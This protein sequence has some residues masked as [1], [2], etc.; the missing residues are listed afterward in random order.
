[1]EPCIDLYIPALYYIIYKIKISTSLK[2]GVIFTDTI[3]YSPN[4]HIL[5]LINSTYKAKVMTRLR[6]HSSLDMHN[7]DNIETFIS[8]ILITYSKT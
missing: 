5:R 6:N 2:W 8:Y 3:I 4:D 1:M 7:L